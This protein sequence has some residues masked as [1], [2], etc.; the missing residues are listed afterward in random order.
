MSATHMRTSAAHIRAAGG[1][2]AFIRRLEGQPSLRTHITAKRPGEKTQRKRKA[3]LP[4]CPTEDQEQAVVIA[5]AEAMQH[6]YPPLARL[7]HVPN[8]GDRHKAVAAKLVAQGVKSGVPD[9]CLPVARRGYH[10]LYVEMKRT[11]GGRVSENQKAWLDSLNAEGYR[12][13][14]CRGAAEAIREIKNYLGVSV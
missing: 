9:L 7:H 1:L 2:E 12:A 13:V 3:T 5:W 6:C 8:G 4:A 10:G 14:I 11:T